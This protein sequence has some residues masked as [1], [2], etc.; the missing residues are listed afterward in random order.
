MTYSYARKSFPR[1][2]RPA[3]TGGGA[4]GWIAVVV[5]VI[6]I[7]ALWWVKSQGTPED[8]AITVSYTHL[9]PE[10]KWRGETWRD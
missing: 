3:G 8:T 7:G 9:G 5:L 2:R 10:G 6:A 4:A 1:R